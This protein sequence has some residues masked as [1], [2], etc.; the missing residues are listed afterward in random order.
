VSG[1]P[2]DAQLTEDVLH[3]VLDDAHADASAV[4][5]KVW[6]LPGD[7]QVVLQSHH[8]VTS[9]GYAHPTAA[10]IAVAERLLIEEGPKLGWPALPWD[11]TLPSSV[12]AAEKALGVDAL[13]LEKL[14]KRVETVLSELAK[15]Q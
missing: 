10:V 2:Q 4:I 11:R 3:S 1:A 13:G 8:S 7:I 12:V 15:S 5:A 14:R 9:G 6:N